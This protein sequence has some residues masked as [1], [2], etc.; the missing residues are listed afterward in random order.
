MT[1]LCQK[2]NIL[3]N[4]NMFVKKIYHSE[5]F[6]DVWHIFFVSILF[7]WQEVEISNSDY[8]EITLAKGSNGG[9]RTLAHPYMEC[10]AFSI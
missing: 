2:Y 4:K 1:N 7:I 3:Y 8:L 9:H 10:L 5:F 6:I